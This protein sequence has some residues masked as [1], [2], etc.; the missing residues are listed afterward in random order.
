MGE[1]TQWIRLSM[2]E[3]GIRSGVATCNIGPE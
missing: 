1:G 3:G 2:G